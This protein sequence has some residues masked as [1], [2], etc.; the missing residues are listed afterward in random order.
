MAKILPNSSTVA[1]LLSVAILLSGTLSLTD[2][3]YA[4]SGGLSYEEALKALQ[5]TKKHSEAAKSW[6]Q[7]RTI[8]VPKGADPNAIIKKEVIKVPGVDGIKGPTTPQTIKPIKVKAPLLEPKN[9][10]SAPVPKAQTPAPVPSQATTAK[11]KQAGGWDWVSSQEKKKA[12]APQ[13]SPVTTQK[14]VVKPP[15]TKTQLFKPVSNTTS[16]MK[17]VYEAPVTS[18]PKAAVKKSAN[19]NLLSLDS[20]KPAT[21]AQTSEKAAPVKP[22][23]T[24]PQRSQSAN[25]FYNRAVKAHLQGKLSEAIADYSA[26]LRAD[27]NFANAHCNLGQIYNQQHHFDMAIEEFR[28]A[29]S[30][31]PKDEHSYNGLGASMRGKKNYPEAIKNWKQAVSLKPDLA[32]AHY[33]LGAVYEVQKEYDQAILAYE[34]AVKHDYRLGEANYRIGL[35]L[36][37]K[38]RLDEAKEQF[39]KALKVSGKASYSED[40]RKR[41]AK[42]EQISN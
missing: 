10:G 31:N 6:G 3:A 12:V 29:L 35:I 14:P 37:K 22:V 7:R 38:K 9:T 32:T 27:P 36:T 39:S 1:Q 26:A 20:S 19:D 4:Q 8:S 30:I 16:S 11:P 24:P 33:N 34:Q 5:K 18:K 17:T 15:V 23:T 40:A 21:P 25:D 42:L 2:S 28:K 13:V 41:L